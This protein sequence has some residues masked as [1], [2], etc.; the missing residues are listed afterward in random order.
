MKYVGIKSCREKREALNSP[1]TIVEVPVKDLIAGD[2]QRHLE[3]FEGRPALY[4]KF[5]ADRGKKA[6]LWHIGDVYD[7]M[8]EG[9]DPAVGMITVSKNGCR[10]DGSHRAAALYHQGVKTVKVKMVD[11]QTTPELE[12]HIEEQRAKYC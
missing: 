3:C 8:K 9:Y 6:N 10:L 1:G 11:M 12:K 2:C 4:V 7:R 5:Y